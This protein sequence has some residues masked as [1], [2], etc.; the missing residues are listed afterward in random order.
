MDCVE[1]WDKIIDT[2]RTILIWPV[3][4]Y[5]IIFMFRK[6]ICKAVKSLREVIIKRNK[7]KLIF[8]G[9]IEDTEKRFAKM[10]D[11]KNDHAVS[12][13][14][15]DNPKFAVIQAFSLIEQAVYNKAVELKIETAGKDVFDILV[16]FI[17]EQKIDEDAF[18]IATSLFSLKEKVSSAQEDEIATISKEQIETYKRNTK[19]MKDLID[20]I[21]N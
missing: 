14:I 19:R 2:L 8:G 1:I 20:A 18:I 12:F 15:E 9:T 6:P 21:S 16:I 5:F 10:T 4:I 7:L 13:V 3:A 17:T 11:K